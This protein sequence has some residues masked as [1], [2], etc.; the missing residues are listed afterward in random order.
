M[1]IVANQAPAELDGSDIRYR[2]Q[3]V[4]HAAHS[5]FGVSP[6]WV[7]QG[8]QVRKILA[9]YLRPP[10][11]ATYDLPGI[12]DPGEWWHERLWYRSNVPVVGRHSRDN[13]MKWPSESSTLEQVYRIDGQHDIRIMG[14]ARTPSKVLGLSEVPDAWTV[15][16]TDEMPVQDFLRSLDYFVYFQHPQAIEAFGRAILEAI[17]TGIV[18]ILPQ[19][20]EEVFGKAAIYTEPAGVAS[21]IKELHSDSKLYKA[22]LQDSYQELTDRFSYRSYQNKIEGLLSN[23]KARCPH[24]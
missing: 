11:L 2:V 21:K 5:S 15:Y 17:A 14:G 22:Q 20:F 6:T 8:P 1:L 16:D 19:H 7:P 12:L 9:E 24:E 10:K 23:Q 4:D 13:I 3:D 18:V